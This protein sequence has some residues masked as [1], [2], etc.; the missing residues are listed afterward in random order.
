[1]FRYNHSNLN[2]GKTLRKNM[3][4]QERKL[5]FEFLAQLPTKIYRQKLIGNYIVDFYC[6]KSKIAIEL[7]GGQHYED[8]N[9][10]DDAIR[11][12]NLNALGIKVIRY[13]NFDVM[14][15]FDAVCDDIYKNIF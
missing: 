5:W 7:D 6:P 8:A 4:K 2:N 13:S 15:Y 9:S 1:M 14:H 3:T 12:E 10:K 11:T